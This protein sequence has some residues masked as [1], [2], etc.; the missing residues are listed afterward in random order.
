M[1]RTSRKPGELASRIAITD[2]REGLPFSK[3]LLASSLTATG[4]SPSRA[5]RVAEK[6]EEV[7]R[8]RGTP[9]VTR[10]EL[11]TVA[12]DVL[13]REVGER[14]ARAYLNWESVGD[15]EHPLAILIG[16]ATGVGKSTIATQLAARL[17]IVRIVSTDSIREVMRAML[18]PAMI[19]TLHVSSFK[20]DTALHDPIPPSVDRLLVA[21]GEQVAA[22][23][24]GVQAILDRAVAEGTDVIIEGAHL[25]PGSI[26]LSAVEGAIVV[27][28]II[29]VDDEDVHRS[30]FYTR[31]HEAR[32]RPQ[33]RYLSHFHSIRKIQRFVKSLALQKGIP[34]I[35]SYGLD[36][37][38]AAVIDLVVSKA[39]ADVQAGRQAVAQEVPGKG[40]RLGA[41]QEATS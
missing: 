39:T 31:G 35:P 21:F 19:P 12:A 14:Y 29:T 36:A 20:A 11:R 7:L 34:I 24:V 6:V 16:G 2:T 22:V 41:K 9:T 5:Y 4:L 33:E 32:L 37:T 23:A 10:T 13:T 27:P 26:D 17:G 30:H 3:G 1:A 18:S 15:R 28:M 40:T 25:V 38:L 8:G